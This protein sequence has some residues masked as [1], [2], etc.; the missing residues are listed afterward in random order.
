VNVSHP[1]G[2]TTPGISPGGVEGVRSLPD[3]SYFLERY[4]VDGVEG[5]LARLFEVDVEARPTFSAS[6]VAPVPP[7]GATLVETYRVGDSEVRLYELPEAAALYFV[8]PSEYQLPIH[9]LKLI[10]LAREQ[11]RRMP[12]GFVDLRKPG[13]I[14]AYIAK[15]GERLMYA[16][17]KERGIQIG[18][19]RAGE[20]ATIRRLA[21]ILAKYTAGLGIIEILLNDPNVE[22]VF[23]DA[24]AGRTAVY[25]TIAAREAGHQRCVT[26]ISLTEEDREALLARFRFES[27]RP[28]SEA[29]PVLETNLEA[30]RARV[31]VVGR[32]LSPEGLAMA[33]R[34]HSPDPWT[35]PRMIRAGSLTPLAA[36]LLSFLID[37]RSTILIA[38]SRGA[39]KSSLLG[40]LLFEFSRNQRILTIEDTL[41]LPGPQLQDLGY[42]VQSLYIESALGGKGEMSA[43]EALRVCLRLGESAIVLGE[44]RGQEARTLYEAM[45]AGTAG[46][47]VLGTI[48][49]NTS[50]TVYER[51]VH[52][53]GIPPM[54]FSATDIVVIAGLARP[55]GTERSARRVTEVT[56]LAKSR[57]PGHF[58]PLLGYRP[59]TDALEPTEV[60]RRS[61][62]RVLSIARGWGLT[63]EEAL[64]NI[65]ARTE[66][67]RRIVDAATRHQ[68]DDL[69]NAAWVAET[70]SRYASLVEDGLRGIGL[71]EE[72]TDWFSKAM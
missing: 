69:L 18:R 72:W 5:A 66:I 32:P 35:L 37:G 67:R 13:E 19:D 53:L 71:V 11:L 12:P 52:D 61:S 56:E 40:A 24:P 70:N 21:E 51:I 50:T 44:V 10:H 27:G 23:V 6:W 31:T 57:G 47:A 58:D 48:H 39:G 33:L 16:I 3:V 55:G 22:D 41:E 9:H 54:A 36:G 4:D 49:G 68:R 65:E 2:S 62:E 15:I 46:S 38:G 59:E 8:V 34:R 64:E 30:F 20:V 7:R 28:F 14:R 26:N 29:M 25:V 60:F 63:Y 17:A 43:E 45:R 42:K 1:D